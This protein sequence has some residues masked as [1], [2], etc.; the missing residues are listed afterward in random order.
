MAVYSLVQN[1]W[2][3]SNLLTAKSSGS[4]Y[5]SKLR[6]P[7]TPSKR[8]LP[9][10]FR[11][12]TLDRSFAFVQCKR[13]F[14]CDGLGFPLDFAVR[15]ITTDSF[16]LRQWIHSHYYT[17]PSIRQ[18]SFHFFRRGGKFQFLFLWRKR[19]LDFLLYQRMSFDVIMYLKMDFL[20]QKIYICK[21]CRGLSFQVYFQTRMHY[22]RMRTA[23]LLSISPIIHCS[24]GICPEGVYLPGWC[25]YLGG[26][27]A[28]GVPAQGG[29]PT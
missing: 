29:V 26:V 17:A 2:I 27:P 23:R 7:F 18:I 22:S 10:V 21:M 12:Q 28:R 24:R 3:C 20:L 6:A 8:L 19:C 13:A 1:D 5:P 4:P 15:R 14:S 11:E 16:I 25:T 9:S